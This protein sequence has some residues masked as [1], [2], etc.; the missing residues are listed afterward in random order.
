MAVVV[1]DPERAGRAS[2]V[3]LLKEGGVDAR[4]DDNVMVLG[5]P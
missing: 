5:W 1:G 3:R 4:F 2:F